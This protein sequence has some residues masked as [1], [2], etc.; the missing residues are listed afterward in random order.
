[1]SEESTVWTRNLIVNRLMAAALA[2]AEK[3]G[4][5]LGDAKEDAIHLLAS[6][7]ADEIIKPHRYGERS[8]KWK[9]ADLQDRIHEAERG[10]VRYID[11]LDEGD[12]DEDEGE[13]GLTPETA[14]DGAAGGAGAPRAGEGTFV[15]GR[16]GFCPCWPFC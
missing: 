5:T 11:G 13:R 16:T 6:R 15:A 8:E 4:R 1:M 7:G 10:L 12:D 9:T 3:S 2:H 14:G